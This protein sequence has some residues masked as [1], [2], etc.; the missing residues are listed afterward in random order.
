METIN[1]S[2]KTGSYQTKIICRLNTVRCFDNLTAAIL[3]T[4]GANMVWPLQLAA[5]RALIMST[6]LESVMGT[7]HIASGFGYFLLRN[8]HL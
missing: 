8:C 6:W 2:G 3:A 1:R 4:A 5:I 7:P